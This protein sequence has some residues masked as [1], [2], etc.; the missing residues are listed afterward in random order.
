M[1]IENV[2][3]SAIQSQQMVKIQ[4]KK[5]TDQDWVTRELAPYDI[6]DRQDK[7]GHIRRVIL[8]YCWWH[9]DYKAA[10]ILVY[11]DTIGNIRLLDKKFN[12]FEVE[13]LINPKGLP[14]IPRDW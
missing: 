5:E 7:D 13:R 1:A 8:G 4:F 9:K 6:Y 12:G 11:L 3:I 2:L 10:P 14:N